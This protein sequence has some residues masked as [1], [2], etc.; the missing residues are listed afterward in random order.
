MCIG[1]LSLNLLRFITKPSVP[2]TDR[3]GHRLTPLEHA[4]PIGAS[5]LSP[6]AG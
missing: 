3:A 1:R 4:A 6:I 2:R 5:G